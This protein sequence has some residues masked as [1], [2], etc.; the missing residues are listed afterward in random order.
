M[1]ATPTHLAFAGLLGLGACGL[2]ALDHSPEGDDLGAAVGPEGGDTGPSSLPF[3]NFPEPASTRCGSLPEDVTPIEGLGSAWLVVALPGATDSLGN[4]VEVGTARLRLSNR[5]LFDCSA[6]FEV[7]EAL[8]DDEP[9]AEPPSPAWGLGVSLLADELGVEPIDLDGLAD[10]AAELAE[11]GG[12]SA[13][14]LTGELRLFS[15][16]RQCVV[17]ELRDLTLPRSGPS[18]YGGFIAEVCERT[19]VPGRR[20]SCW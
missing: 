20:Q 4:P 3:S 5:P 12:S 7:D 15:V 19:C 1:A 9:P 13:T 18:I 8:D 17:G 11:G 6:A 2:D 16:T 10:P 14:A